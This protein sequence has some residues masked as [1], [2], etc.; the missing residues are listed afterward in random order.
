MEEERTTHD[1]SELSSS[2]V[3]YQ[4]GGDEPFFSW[5]WHCKGHF[6]VN[7]Q[8]KKIMISGE[9]EFSCHRTIVLNVK[10]IKFMVIYRTR[11]HVIESQ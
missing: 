1:D 3:M 9:D 6:Y 7:D 8:C 10:E 2:V 11:D 4:S 5:N